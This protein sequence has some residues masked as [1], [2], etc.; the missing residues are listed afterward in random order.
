MSSFEDSVLMTDESNIK[1]PNL[2]T[3]K[4][5]R[6]RY[7]TYSLAR[8]TKCKLNR[9]TNNFGAVTERLGGLIMTPSKRKSI[10]PDVFASPRTA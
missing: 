10:V 9:T 3:R 2:K 5:V 6:P 1:L 8:D 4:L 7:T